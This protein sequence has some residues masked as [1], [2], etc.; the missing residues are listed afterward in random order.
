MI[1][2]IELNDE[3]WSFVCHALESK[4]FDA[5]VASEQCDDEDAGEIWVDTIAT[6]ERLEGYI[7]TIVCNALERAR[8]KFS[9]N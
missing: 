7:Q 9:E 3:D 2:S 6:S 4:A 8:P 1:I 5:E